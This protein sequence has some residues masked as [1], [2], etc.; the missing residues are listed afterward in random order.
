MTF[1][2]RAITVSGVFD[3]KSITSSSHLDWI[4]PKVCSLH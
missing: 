1:L 3:G 4:Y 2:F